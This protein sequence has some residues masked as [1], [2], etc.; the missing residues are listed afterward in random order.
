[1]LLASGGGDLR[2]VVAALLLANSPNAQNPE[3]MG[4]GPHESQQQALPPNL[5]VKK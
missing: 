5:W 3:G 4:A 2:R 1:M